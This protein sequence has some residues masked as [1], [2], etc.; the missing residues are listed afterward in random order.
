MSKR[1]AC[2]MLVGEMSAKCREYPLKGAT[3]GKIEG[4]LKRYLYVGNSTTDRAL[5]LV[6]GCQIYCLSSSMRKY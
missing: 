4:W 2:Q 3:M 6:I 5:P 1:F